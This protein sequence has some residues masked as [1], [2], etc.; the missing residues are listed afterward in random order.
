MSMKIENRFFQGVKIQQICTVVRSKE[1]RDED[2]IGFYIVF[3]V[4]K[5]RKFSE[6]FFFAIIGCE[7]ML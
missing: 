3:N 4:E 7:N 2:G 1:M 5:E 6:R